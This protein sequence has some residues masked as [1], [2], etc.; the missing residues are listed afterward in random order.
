[1]DRLLRKRTATTPRLTL[2]ARAELAS[3]PWPGNIREMERTLD[4]ALATANSN[5]LDLSDIP[6][7]SALRQVNDEISG[8]EA[9]LDA[10]HW[11]M[12]LTARRLGVNRSTVLRR[13]RK[14]GLQAPE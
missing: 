12:A 14:A 7:A 2:A 3:R 8:L 5:T 4:V 9:M 6:A 1:L 13:V 11:N 10:C